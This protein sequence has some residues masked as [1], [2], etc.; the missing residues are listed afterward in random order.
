[1]TRTRAD[2][3]MLTAVL[4]YERVRNGTVSAAPMAPK[5]GYRLAKCNVTMVSER[6]KI[7]PYAIQMQAE[8]ARIMGVSSDLVSAM[9]T[10]S[11]R[12]GFTGREKGIA[13]MAT[14]TLVTA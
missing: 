7:G 8:L 13:A 1:M 4:Q 3:G 5:H 2:R 14:A 11:E 12:L 9:P 10:K 6:P